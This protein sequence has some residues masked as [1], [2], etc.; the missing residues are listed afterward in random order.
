MVAQRL[1]HGKQ[2]SFGALIS[3]IAIGSVA[4]GIGTLILAFSIYEGFK[5]GVQ[6]KLFLHTGH[7]QIEKFT[8]NQSL[9]EHPFDYQATG[10]F[11]YLNDSLSPGEAYVAPYAHKWAL[12]K[13]EEEVSGIL[14]K[15]IDKRYPQKRLENALESGRLPQIE[16]L[17]PA[18]EIAISRKIANT[19]RLEVGQEVIV[20]FIQQ[21]P[22]ARKVKVVGIYHTGLE[23][24]DDISVIGDLRLLQRISGWDSLQAGGI[25]IDLQDFSKL[26]VLQERISE[27]MDMDLIQQAV[28]NRYSHFFDWF[29]M[30]HQNVLIFL[31]VILF[32]A[33][34]NIL[35]I[36]LILIIERTRMIG[37]L[38]ALGATN[39]QIQQIF[40]V[41]G[42]RI[43]LKGLLIGNT[44]ILLLCWL[45]S[46]FHLM[47]LD[48]ETY[49]LDHVP[50]LV[51]WQHVLGLNALIFLLVCSSLFIPTS[52]ISG[53]LPIKAIRFD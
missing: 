51:L 17:A 30:L 22:K 39:R 23:E 47:P 15:G 37:T 48:P 13:T 42:I 29:Q 14:I 35:S 8:A 21:P 53:I 40:V 26:P 50:V 9:E 52:I 7:I 3:R 4:L 25:Q 6:D 44:A 43:T 31:F 27:A 45:Q 5:E 20:Y 33:V 28:T 19:L 10:I 18:Q 11:K 41:N 2:G 32:V 34:F 16:A 24:F 46:Q 36:M 1:Q 49:Y 38:K 12:L